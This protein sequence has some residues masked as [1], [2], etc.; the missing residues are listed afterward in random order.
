VAKEMVYVDANGDKQALGIDLALVKEAADKGFSVKELINA[1]FPTNAER[2][3]TAYEQALE[4]TGIFVG[5]N[6]AAGIRKVNFDDI[7][8]PANEAN[9][10]ITRDGVP[11]SRILFPIAIL[12]TIEDKLQVNRD[13]TPNALS[14]MIAMEDSVQGTKFERAVLNFTNPEAARSAPV[15]QLAL[16]NVMLSVT[17]SDKSM[18]IPSW[19]LGMEISE[20]A[21]K[22]TTLDLVGLALGRQASVER[23]ERAN[24]YILKLLQGDTDLSMVALSAISNKVVTAQ[25]L[26]SGIT[27]AGTLSQKAWLTWLS[28]NST[29]RT[30]THIVTNLATAMAIENRSGK[31]TVQN[32]NPNSP[33]MD[34]LFSVINP[35]WPANVKIFLTEDANW[36][37]NTIMGFDKNYGIHKVSS[38]SAQYSAVES[39]ALKRS[40][41]MR[42]DN[43]ELLYRLFDEA[44]EVLTLTV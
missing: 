33:R 13:T 5:G 37:A 31:P 8:N 15:S 36:P 12:D 35:V 14:Q 44:F 16:P 19:S 27:T 1:K 29:K 28:T 43:G 21:L 42:F 17:A 10:P 38:L 11:A 4:Q 18:A 6:R 24:G 2:D 20:Q 34:T 32:D 23:N 9:S 22:I 25:S 3:G 26:D 30:I 41:A 39:F 7:L 40:T